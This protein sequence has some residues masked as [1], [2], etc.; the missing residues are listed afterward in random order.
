MDSGARLVLIGGG[1]VWAGRGEGLQRGT[2]GAVAGRIVEPFALSKEAFQAFTKDAEVMDES[3]F[4]NI[5]ALEM[6]VPTDQADQVKNT[7]LIV[8]SALYEIDGWVDRYS[9]R[10][11]DHVLKHFRDARSALAKQGGKLPLS[12]RVA[13]KSLAKMVHFLIDVSVP[14]HSAKILTFEDVGRYTMIPGEKERN[15]YVRGLIENLVIF[16]AGHDA[17]EQ[18]AEERSE[19]V[20]ALLPR[21]AGQMDLSGVDD[22]EVALYLKNWVDGHVELVKSKYSEASML[23][24]EWQESQ[25]DVKAVEAI[26]VKAVKLQAQCLAPAVD[27]AG[28]LLTVFYSPKAG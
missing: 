17:Y 3:L 2:H 1:R 12:D 25:G 26:E 14:F 23:M 11:A 10:A 21:S 6:E 22:A 19:Q 8:M 16:I 4:A 15:E 24:Q 18:I 28:K 9:T 27:V 7:Y 20:V 5:L 13:T